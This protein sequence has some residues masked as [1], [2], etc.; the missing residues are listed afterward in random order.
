MIENKAG[1]N[2][3]IIVA[4]LLGL[5]AVALGAIAAHAVTDPKAVA[6]LEKAA[7]YQLIHV[8]VLF[9]TAR[10]QDRLVQA[11]RWLFMIGIFLFCGSIEMKYLLGI[12]GATIVAPA[13]GVC[14]MLGWFVL[15]ISGISLNANRRPPDKT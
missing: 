15:G 2:G 10:S 5:L 12:Q 7:I 13:G 11:C 9:F 3:W 8:V 1:S 4:G 14:L 6:S